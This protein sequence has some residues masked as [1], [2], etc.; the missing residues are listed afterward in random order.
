[1]AVYAICSCHIALLC[2]IQYAISNIISGIFSLT[3]CIFIYKLDI[4]LLSCHIVLHIYIYIYMS[5]NT[6]QRYQYANMLN[7]MQHNVS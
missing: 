2:I 6:Q 3:L 7:K 1:M 4:Y 5:H